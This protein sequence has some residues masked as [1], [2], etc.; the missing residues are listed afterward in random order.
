MKF[1]LCFSFTLIYILSSYAQS[2]KIVLTS[3]EITPYNDNILTMSVE[4]NDN[5]SEA[6]SLEDMFPELKEKKIETSFELKAGVEV[7]RKIAAASIGLPLQFSNRF[8]LV[9]ELSIIAGFQASASFR[10]KYRLFSPRF[11]L[12]IQ[13]GIGYFYFGLSGSPCAL[14]ALSGQYM[15]GRKTS[16]TLELKTIFVWSDRNTRGLSVEGVD[17]IKSPPT[18]LSIGIGF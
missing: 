7:F 2:D 18:S 6:D 5:L 3:E 8:T 12:N 17:I 13:P 16:L 9:P 14:L 11:R 4:R 1:V 15:M 10:F